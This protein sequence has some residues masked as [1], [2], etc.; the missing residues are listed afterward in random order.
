MNKNNEI[1]GFFFREF[2]RYI[3]NAW[4]VLFIGVV[5]SD[6]LTQGKYHYL[7]A[8]F[9]I[10]YGAV[11]SIFVGTKEF[12]R[13]YDLHEGQKHPGEIFVVLWSILLFGMVVYSWISGSSY[14][15]PS[16]IISVY[17]MVL[18]VFAITQSSKTIYRSKKDKC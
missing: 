15:I 8:S 4:T 7:M 13:W 2:W 1:K 11:L 3:T 10:I 6:F 16:D 12:S 14:A 17:I 5:I 18:T 9:S